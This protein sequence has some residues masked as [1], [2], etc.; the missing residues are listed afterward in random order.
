MIV[1]ELLIKILNENHI[2]LYYKSRPLEELTANNGVLYKVNDVDV[3][4]GID[5]YNSHFESPMEK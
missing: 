1:K 2:G 3:D 4:N 5:E